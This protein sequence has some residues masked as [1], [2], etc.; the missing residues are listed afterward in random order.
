M[1]MHIALPIALISSFLLISTGCNPPRANSA[2]VNTTMP[3]FASQIVRPA[4]IL[5]TSTPAMTNTA[6]A[7]NTPSARLLATK[8]TGVAHQLASST[9]VVRQ[10]QA[11]QPSATP[12]ASLTPGPDAWKDLP[13]VPVIS[14]D[15]LMIYQRGLDLGNNP[16]AFSKIG[17]CGSTPAWFLGDFDRGSRYYRLG[18]YQYLQNVIDYFNGSFDRTSLAARS[19]FNAPAL[20][21]PLWA[22]RDY[23][24]SNE[25]PLDCEYRVQK[26]VIAFVMLG[27]NDVWHPQEFEPQMRKI[28]EYLIDNGVIPILATKAD[29][30][31]GDG[32]INAT[33]SRLA[34]EYRIPLWN[35]W[36]A[37][38]PLPDHGLQ[39]DQ[40][41][42][43]WGGNFF[44]KPDSLTKAWP[45]R[46]LTA[47]QVLDSVWKKITLQ[48][49]G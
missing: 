11:S 5:E 36:A 31:E 32:K 2:A 7:S 6:A 25:S 34:E 44:N 26:P 33:I 39:E 4:P 12:T 40:V 13:V 46:N 22:D 20:F 1:K 8:K 18:D 21:V 24:A 28:I 17:D 49:G 9:P 43:T 38:Y 29:N 42:L 16:H 23:C 47:L 45:L 10:S 19:G 30:Q 15:V 41:H 48:T 37:V 27:A 35:F 14:N 3:A